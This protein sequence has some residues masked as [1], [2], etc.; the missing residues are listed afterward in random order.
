MKLTSAGAMLDY[1]TKDEEGEEHI[2][3]FD[4]SDMQVVRRDS[5]HED[6]FVKK[7]WKLLE[8]CLDIGN[9]L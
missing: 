4:L 3:L 8:K 1:M 5:V 7:Q 9:P 2:V 6:Q